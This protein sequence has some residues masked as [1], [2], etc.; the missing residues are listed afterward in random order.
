MQSADKCAI[1]EVRAQDRST[2][3]GWDAGLLGSITL[4]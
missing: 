2:L 1:C 4:L 3:V